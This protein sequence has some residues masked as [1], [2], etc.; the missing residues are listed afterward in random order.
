MFCVN[1]GKPIEDGKTMCEACAAAQ[2]MPYN[3]AEEP[4]YQPPYQPSYEPPYQPVAEPQQPTFELNNPVE[5]PKKG[6]KPKA[7][8]TGKR[9]P[10]GLVVAATAV[11]GIAA[12]AVFCWDTISSF[13]VRSFGSPEDYMTHVEE[14]VAEENINSFTSAYGQ[15]LNAMGGGEME[16][17][18]VKGEMHLTFGEDLLDLI[19]L[20]MTASGTDMDLGWLSDIKMTVSSSIDGDLAEAEMGIGLGKTTIATIN[21]ILDMENGDCYMTVPEL[22]GTYLALSMEDAGLDM[23]QFEDYQEMMSDFVKMMPSEKKM[24]EILIKYWAIVLANV[25][26]VEKSTETVEVDG[27]EQKLNVITFT[28]TDENLI[29]IAIAILEDIQDDEELLECAIGIYEKMYPGYGYL[30]YNEET[31]EYE[32]VFVEADHEE[33]IME[34]L[35]S[36]LESLEEVKDEL[37][38]DVSINVTTYIDNSDKIMGRTI[39]VETPDDSYEAYYIT[40]WEKNEF[41]FEAN[42]ADMIEITGSGSREKKLLSGEYEISVDGEHMLTLEVED[43]DEKA[44]EEGYINGTFTL[45][46]SDDVMEKIIDEMGA[47]GM[48]AYLDF[49]KLALEVKLANTATSNDIALNIK[50]GGSTMFG[51]SLYAEYVEGDSIKVPSKTVDMNDQEALMEWVMDMDFEQLI[52]N[53]EDAGVSDMIVDALEGVIGY[54]DY[55]DNYSYAYPE[56]EYY[57]G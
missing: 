19:E 25:E 30:E 37:D 52:S 38:G 10:V 24:N 16:H 54:L 48:G 17:T 15:M 53:L 18:G 32:E 34:A 7:P 42:I 31:G 45:V 36:A 20:G 29:D 5:P 9:F 56:E 4:A 11:V 2:S 51:I 22:T 27:L 14:K 26:D 39:E 33:I 40:V 13:F 6:K 57:Y 49:A 35:D 1:C 23:S 55:Y 28:V 12:A 3:P 43:Y 44:A 46:P 50:M 21:M 8:K 41:A 47:T